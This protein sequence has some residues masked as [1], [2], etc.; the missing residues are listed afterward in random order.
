MTTNKI[1]T[2]Y[3]FPPIPDRNFD[4]SAIRYDY[5]PGDIIGYGSTEKEAINDLINQEKEEEL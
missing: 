3:D 5:D 4:W 1:I 2:S